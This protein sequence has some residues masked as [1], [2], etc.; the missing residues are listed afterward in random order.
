M[1][2]IRQTTTTTLHSTLGAAAADWH[3]TKASLRRYGF[4]NGVSHLLACDQADTAETTL[5]DFEYAMA[6]LQSENGAGA[7]PMS[8]DYEGVLAAG[9]HSSNFTLWEA[10]MRERAHLLRRGDER[11]PAKKI[12]LQLAVE[13]A[14]DSPVTLAAEAWLED[15]NCDWLWLRR[16]MRP[17]QAVPSA[18]LRVFEGHGADVVGAQGITDGR[19]MSWSVDNTLRLWCLRSG[20][21]L[22][23][24]EIHPDGPNYPSIERRAL[25]LTNNRVLTWVGDHGSDHHHLRLWDTEQGEPIA[26]LRGHSA[27]V[28]GAT[29]LADGRLLSWSD[30]HTLR[31]WDGESGAALTVLKGHTDKVSGAQVLPFD[32]LL[33]WAGDPL[34]CDHNLRLWDANSGEII[35]ALRGH[36]DKVSGACALPDGR[37]LSW[38]HDRDLRLWDANSGE[39]IAT[40]T[41]HSSAVLGAIMLPNQR[42]VSWSVDNTLILWN[43]CSGETIAVLEGHKQVG[44]I[45][46]AV[47]SDGRILSWAWDRTLRLWDGES[48]AALATLKGHTNCITGAAGLSDGRIMSWSQDHTIRL[49]DDESGSA[50]ISLEG[51]VG[52]VNGAIE[53]NN[54]QVLSWSD[55]RTLRLWDT[56]SDNATMATEQHTD[57]ILGS[58]ILPDERLVTWSKDRT[59]R[60]WDAEG[61]SCTHILQGHGSDVT[62][63]AALPNDR[64]VSWSDGSD[65]GLLISLNSDYKLRIWD[66]KTGRLLNTLA[67]HSSGVKGATAISDARIVSWAGNILRLWS[68]ETGET[69]ATLKGHTRAVRGAAVLPDGRFMS[70]SNDRTLRTWDHDSGTALE[71]FAFASLKKEAPKILKALRQALRQGRLAHELTTGQLGGLELVF[72]DAVPECAT[73]WHSDGRWAVGQ[74]QPDGKL[75]AHSGKRATL[76]HL[77]HG[78]RQVTLDEAKALH[79][80]KVST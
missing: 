70:W 44:G 65:S 21:A 41:G 20:A 1:A 49:W 5:T 15:G 53:L 2:R 8:R 74:L 18:C 26:L 42:L 59:L 66:T 27:K 19:F 38:S 32:R 35:A 69:V 46:A 22:Q 17:K 71:C 6:R 56:N 31:L 7:L 24:L 61:A 78:N 50:L 76:L 75:L 33:S 40:L 36:T 51:H 10:F 16:L 3:H 79:D 54:G 67:G 63:A 28:N 25:T 29:E 43:L 68:A 45:G 12:L 47:L 52:E 13:H 4:R 9:Q 73:G 58:L 60:L 34:S 80:C 30:D 55:D 77:L 39:I 23:A 62:G 48:G 11:W 57:L 37:L 72:K 14:D 64:I